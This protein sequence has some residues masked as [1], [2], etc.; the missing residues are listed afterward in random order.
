M[1]INSRNDKLHTY[2][3]KT[4]KIV[5]EAQY[6][7]TEE[8]RKDKM[9]QPIDL[10]VLAV[11][12]YVANFKQLDYD[13]DGWFILPIAERDK[14]KAT[15]IQGYLSK[16]GVKVGEDT[17]RR[18]VNKLVYLSYLQY[19]KGY[20]HCSTQSQLSEI[21]ILKGTVPMLMSSDGD[22]GNSIS[23][24]SS[25]IA[26]T[27]DTETKTESKTEKENKTET[28]PERM[29]TE[30]E[31]IAD[32]YSTSLLGA[33]LLPSTKDKE[34]TIANGGEDWI[35]DADPFDRKVK[36]FERD[37]WNGVF[38]SAHQIKIRCCIDG[39][40]DSSDYF[41]NEYE[42]YQETLRKAGDNLH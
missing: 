35:E 36:N 19:K 28:H 9:L 10:N 17:V 39:L 4:N 25:V 31:S 40:D 21:K 29:E 8:T 34:G 16:W 32:R 6:M 26:V 7:L 42:H 30:T 3:M 23:G 33:N 27:T 18:S 2:T 5:D 13:K 12:Q 22:L 14:I 37:I 15:S 24:S 20:Y 11:C 38:E 1:Y 41:L